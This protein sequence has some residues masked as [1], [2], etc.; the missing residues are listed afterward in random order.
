MIGLPQS[1]ANVG[2]HQTYAPHVIT[3]NGIVLRLVKFLGFY[4]PAATL[5]N[6]R[7]N[8]TDT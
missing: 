1:D 2:P 8:V 3:G 7:E 6:C 4:E 5:A